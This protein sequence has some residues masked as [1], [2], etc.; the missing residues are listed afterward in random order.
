MDAVAVS[1][2]RSACNDAAHQPQEAAAANGSA[3][4]P[5]CKTAIHEA[6]G[7]AIRVARQEQGDTQEAFALQAGLDPSEMAAIE[8]GELNLTVDALLKITTQLDISAYTLLRRA[9]L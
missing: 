9:G 1:P 2:L 4:I 6:I 8:R 7:Q 3:V 5:P